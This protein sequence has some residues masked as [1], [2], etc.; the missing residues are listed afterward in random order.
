MS[1]A[2]ATFFER[3]LIDAHDR[4]IE[5][6][7]TG[8][9]SQAAAEEARDLVEE[10]VRGTADQLDALRSFMGGLEVE[11]ESVNRERERL[12][13]LAE[14]TDAD[15]RRFRALIVGAMQRSGARR[16]RGERSHFFLSTWTE[17]RITDAGALPAELVRVVPAERIPLK[18]RITAAIRS[19]TFVPGAQ[20][21]EGEERLVIR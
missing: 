5:A 15:R 2:H 17:L 11:L 7:A 20:L 14:E 6:R 8:V 13:R 1:T 10:Y 4:L 16:V 21:I 3:Q 18:R 19:G 9:D 12:G